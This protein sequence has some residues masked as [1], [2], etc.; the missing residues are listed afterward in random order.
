LTSTTTPLADGPTIVLAL[1]YAANAI[2]SDCPR[3][4]TDIVV[5]VWAGGVKP[6]AGRTQA[7]HL[8]A[9]HL[10]QS[11]PFAIGDVDDPDNYVHLCFN[12]RVLAKQVSCAAGI[13]VDPRGDL[14]PATGTTIHAAHP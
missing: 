1:Q 5:A 10:D 8:A 14:N 9:Y 3:G 2:A 7:D 11:V 6:A 13:V 12:Q 4:T